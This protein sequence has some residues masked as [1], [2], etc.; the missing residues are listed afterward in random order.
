ALVVFRAS[1][2]PFERATR[3]IL[4]L[5]AAHLVPRSAPPACSP[6]RGTTREKARV[7]AHVAH[8]LAAPL[9]VIIGTTD[10]LAPHVER[11]LV[12]RLRRQTH[13]LMQMTSDLIEFSRLDAPE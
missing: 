13:L 10:L 7:L 3:E 1:S 6:Q 12:E 11:S 9:H 4:A 8:D 5:F 2:R